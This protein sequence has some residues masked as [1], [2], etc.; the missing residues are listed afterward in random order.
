MKT[1]QTEDTKVLLSYKVRQE[2]TEKG[3]SF[4]WNWDDY[5]YYKSLCKNAFNKAFDITQ[6]FISESNASSDF[7]EYLF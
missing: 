7:N 2:L 3:Y 4:L 5:Y 6:K 1:T